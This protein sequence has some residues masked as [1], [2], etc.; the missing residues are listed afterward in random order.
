M[1]R[2]RLSVRV[3]VVKNGSRLRVDVDPNR[4][5]ADYRFAVHRKAGR[6][7]RPMASSATRGVADVRVL[8]LPRGTYRVLVPAQRGHTGTTSAPVRVLR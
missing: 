2:L 5:A 6:A 7:W 3:W 4:A 8:D 1:M